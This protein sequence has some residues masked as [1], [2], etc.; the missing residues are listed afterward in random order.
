MDPRR[1][2]VAEAYV[3]WLHEWREVARVAVNRRDY[4]IALGLAQRR[5]NG[6]DTDS[7][8]AVSQVVAS[9]GPVVKAS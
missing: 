8:P 2:T 3:D 5:T 1:R 6:D 9:S 4:R 7:E